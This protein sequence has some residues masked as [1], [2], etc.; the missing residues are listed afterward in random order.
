MSFHG[1]CP[2]SP[3]RTSNPDTPCNVK[4]GIY[5][6]RTGGKPSGIIF[7]VQPIINLSVICERKGRN[8]H[9]S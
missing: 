8:A 4:K 9:F 6:Q 3:D 2:V 5:S 7:V 1:I